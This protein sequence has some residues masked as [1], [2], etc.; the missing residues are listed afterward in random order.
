MI[1]NAPIS[2][3][4]LIDKI[5]ILLIKN[6]KINDEIKKIHVSKE[7]IELQK[8]L[9]ATKIDDKKIEPLIK[10]LKEINLKLWNIENQIRICEKKNN[11]K[12]DFI[13]LAR[14]V[15]KYNDD[16]AKIKLII[17]NDFG[18]SLIEIKSYEDY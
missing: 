18:S 17:N 16:R 11:F 14:S 1:V 3:G 15:Y 7:L 4:E 6:E 13:Q 10:Q 12:D 8:V 5:T 9:A 2:L